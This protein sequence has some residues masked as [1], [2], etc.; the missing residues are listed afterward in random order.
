[1]EFFDVSFVGIGENKFTP[2]FGPYQPSSFFSGFGLFGHNYRIQSDN[3]IK[4][5]A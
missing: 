1:M 4:F 3:S 2:F 5:R